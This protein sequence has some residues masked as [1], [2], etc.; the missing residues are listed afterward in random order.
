MMIDTAFEVVPLNQ[1]NFFTVFITTVI[2]IIIIYRQNL[3]C[4]VSRYATLEK[5][6]SLTI[7]RQSNVIR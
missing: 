5:W 2:V 6:S 4:L 3:L 7:G 1:S